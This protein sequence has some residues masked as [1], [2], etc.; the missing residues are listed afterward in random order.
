MLNRVVLLMVIVVC[1]VSP[2]F[3]AGKI[4]YG[5]RAGATVTIKSMSGLDTSHAMI[6][7]EHT[8][9]DAI[10]FCKDYVQEDPVTEK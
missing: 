10:G 2:A 4:Y 6:Q 7:A 9:E 8:R 1:W 5:S 3:A